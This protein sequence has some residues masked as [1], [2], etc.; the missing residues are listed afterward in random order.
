MDSS[1]QMAIGSDVL[2]KQNK[3]IVRHEVFVLEKVLDKA[4]VQQLDVLDELDGCRV[5]FGCC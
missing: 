5:S 1:P 4:V 3:I 2:E